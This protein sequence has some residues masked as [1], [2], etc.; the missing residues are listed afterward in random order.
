MYLCQPIT[1]PSEWIWHVED[2]ENDK[3]V[4][5]DLKLNPEAYTGYQGQHIWHYIYHENCYQGSISEMCREERALIKLLSGLHASISTQLSEFY[6]DLET[7][8]TYPN[9]SV[10]F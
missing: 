3:G 8:R 9:Y 2:L 4:Y 1:A 7:N 5:V 6:V 10:Y